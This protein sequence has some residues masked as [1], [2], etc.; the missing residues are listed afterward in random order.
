MCDRERVLVILEWEHLALVCVCD[1]LVER[2]E[3]EH[4]AL[5]CVCDL[6]VERVRHACVQSVTFHSLH[7]ML[8][9]TQCFQQCV[10]SPLLVERV[11]HACVQSVTFHSL[12]GSFTRYATQAKFHAATRASRTIVVHSRTRHDLA[13]FRSHFST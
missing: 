8:L 7:G 2:V 10:P 3:W 13:E 12:H 1:R 4:L 9:F 6:L 11:R 5:V